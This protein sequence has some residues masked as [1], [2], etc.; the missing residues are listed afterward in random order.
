MYVV[1]GIFSLVGNI[2]LLVAD[3]TLFWMELS[4]FLFHI[5]YIFDIRA[6]VDYSHS[7]FIFI[8]FIV[9]AL[10]VSFLLITTIG[11]FFLSII[12]EKKLQSYLFQKFKSKIDKSLEAVEPV[13]QP[14]FDIQDF[15]ELV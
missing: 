9:P 1:L 2:I 5:D 10:F 12:V 7:D 15:S 11:I 14:G 4:F 8:N 3:I 13:E 6:D